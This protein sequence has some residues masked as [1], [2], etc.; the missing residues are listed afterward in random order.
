M[1]TF[2]KQPLLLTIIFLLSM[3]FSSMPAANEPKKLTVVSLGDSITFGY[4]LT[5]PTK[6][7]FPYL[8]GN[9]SNEVINISYPGWTSTQ[10]L[11]KLNENGIDTMLQQADVITLNIGA[12]DLIE[13][14]GVT[15]LLASQQPIQLTPEQLLGIV[16]TASAPLTS[17]LSKTIQLIRLHTDAPI[18]LYSLYNPFAA[19]TDP[20]LGSVHLIGEQI[21]TNVNQL[22]IRP[23]AA[24]SGS[25]YLDAYSAFN[26]NQSN[27]IIPGDIHPTIAGHQALAQLATNAIIALQPKEITIDKPILSTEEETSQPVVVT[28]GEIKDVEL[29]KW[30]P[31]EKSKEDFSHAGNVVNGNSFEVKENGKY[32]IYAKTTSGSEAVKV[33][34]IDNI[35]PEV[36]EEPVTEDLQQKNNQKK[37]NH[38]L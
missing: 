23:I 35:V 29:L 28:I 36:E 33:F 16:N 7:A 17:N 37:I 22:I 27:Y 20:F 12:N 2:K 26:G 14:V 38:L 9:K 5:E 11:A 25:I 15:D 34:E 32:T 6:N 4:G 21:T 8:I 10:L 18:L 30:L 19:S 31:G 3:V 1:N 24:Q 13:A